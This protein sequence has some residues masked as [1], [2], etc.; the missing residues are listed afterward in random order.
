VEAFPNGFLGVLMPQE[1]LLSAPHRA[2]P[3][4]DFCQS[5]DSSLLDSGLL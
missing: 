2:L 1:E 4:D 5:V 3:L